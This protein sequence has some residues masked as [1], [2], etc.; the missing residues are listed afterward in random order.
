MEYNPRYGQVITDCA[1]MTSRDGLHFKRYDE[2]FMRPC[3]EFGNNWTYGDCYPARGFLETAS[4]IKGADPELSMLAPDN[5]WMGEHA[6]LIRYSMRCDGFVSLHAGDKEE[7]IVT[8]PFTFEGGELHI[9]FATSAWGYLYITLVAED[10]TTVESG[11]IFGNKIDRKVGFP[12]GAVAALAG[13]A[14]TMEVRMRDADLYS[15]QFA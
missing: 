4:D 5:H 14:V 10:G 12:A 3:P 1:F 2:A 6:R 9:N 8:K 11:E 15:M 7:C 13:K